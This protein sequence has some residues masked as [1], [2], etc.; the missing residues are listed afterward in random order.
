MKL[1]NL[2]YPVY[3]YDWDDL[4]ISHQMVG[5]YGM[6]FFFFNIGFTTKSALYD[7]AG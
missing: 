5:F 2:L 4:F 1:I 3:P 6:F 7:K